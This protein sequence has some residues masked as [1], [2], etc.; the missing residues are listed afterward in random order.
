MIRIGIVG[1]GRILNAHL[2]GYRLLREAGFDDF[3]ITALCARNRDD[4]LMFRKRGEGPPPRAAVLAPE[5]GDPLAAPHIYLDEFQPDT[6]VAV[7][8]DYREMIAAGVVD[9]VNDFTTLSMHHQIGA[10]AFDAGLHLLVQKPLAISVAAGRLLVERA[11]AE[12]LTLGLFENVRQSAGTRAAAWAIRQGLIGDLQLA[13]LGGI[14]G[15]WSPDKIVGETPWRHRKLE[16]AGGGAIDIGV[17]VMHMIR[18][19]CGEVEA[20]SGTVRTFEPMRYLY[21]DPAAGLEVEA[22]VDDTYLATVTCEGGALAQ[23]MWSWGGHGEE[24]AIPGAPVF[25]G[26]EGC[27]KGGEIIA[28]SGSRSNLQDTFWAEA[29]PALLDVQFPKVGPNET[30]LTDPFAIQQYDWL[31]AIARGGQPETDGE[32][33]LRD[34]A[35]AFGMIE[36]SLLERT[37][38][39]AE[40]LSGEVKGYQQEIDDH[41]GLA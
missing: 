38:T 26:S 7:F 23:L 11:K 30:R 24:T 12:G 29:D 40:L 17:H 2:H 37:V 20:V 15:L 27:I 34:L 5:T 31:D 22:N 9:A 10:A 8:T 35:A 18:Y 25:Y 41:F 33:G 1:C 21:G 28:D 36:S 4:A 6:D 14:G 13:L 39:L 16:G 3:R 19:I 32:E